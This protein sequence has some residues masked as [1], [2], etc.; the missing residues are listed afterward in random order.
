MAVVTVI[1]GI[2]ASMTIPSMV[3]LMGKNSLQSSMSQ[4]NGAIQEAQ[5]S[6]IKN[7]QSCTIN[8]SATGVSSTNTSTNTCMTSPVS[9]SSGITLSVPTGSTMPS[10]LSFS[11][12][13]NT[14]TALTLILSST[15]TSTQR[16][17]VIS[18]GIGI[19]RS[20]IYDGTNC[21]SSF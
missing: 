19:M 3:G 4:I 15:K 17:L 5:R 10:T 8:L 12:K 6:A 13:G 9:L 1:T 7:G 20:G 14:T 16:C 18:A 2:L 21:N 11:Y